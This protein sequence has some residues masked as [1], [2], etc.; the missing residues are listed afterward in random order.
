[1]YKKILTSVLCLVVATTSALAI[2]IDENARTWWG[3][4]GTQ[5]PVTGNDYGEFILAGGLGKRNTHGTYGD[6]WG[7]V[8]MI[9]TKLVERGGYFCPYQLQCANKKKKKKSW[10]LYFHPNGFSHDKCVWLCEGGYSGTNCETAPNTPVVCDFTPQD[11]SSVGKFSGLSMKTSGKHNDGKEHEIAG[12]NQWGTDPECDVIVGITQYL[13]HGVVARPIQA[14]CGRDNWKSVDSYVDTIK[15]AS[16]N[17]KI[18]CAAGFTANAEQTDCVPINAALCETQSLTFC[19]GFERGQY[20]S[21]IHTLAQSGDCHKYF[22]KDQN[23]AFPNSNSKECI[24]CATGIMG[25]A[26]PANGVCEKCSSGQYY[27]KDSASCKPAAALTKTE[28]QYGAGKTKNTASLKDQ[29]WTKVTPDEYKDCVFG[30]GTDDDAADSRGTEAASY[31]SPTYTYGTLR[32]DYNSTIRGNNGPAV[33]TGSLPTVSGGN[34]DGVTFKVP[35][36]NNLLQ[37]NTFKFQ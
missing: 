2:T 26:N 33:V 13:T 18:L 36:N 6:E 30:K 15:Y 28:L 10:T 12:L 7:V 8:G 29:C 14:C 31:D 35:L 1:M 34:G 22:C 5:M 37:T 21:A 32:N 19:S 23:K 20:N 9:A 25:G 16:G 24:D 4:D 27:D 3:Y 11:P 17:K